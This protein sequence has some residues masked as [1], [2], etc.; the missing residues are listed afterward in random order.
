ML[1]LFSTFTVGHRC[2][3]C[4]CA[5]LNHIILERTSG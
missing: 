2:S 3:Y 5:E 4:D 1:E